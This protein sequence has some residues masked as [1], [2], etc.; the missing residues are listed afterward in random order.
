MFAVNAQWA[1]AVLNC[2]DARRSAGGETVGAVRRRNT[3][4]TERRVIVTVTTGK[5]AKVKRKWE[6]V[7]FGSIKR[8]NEG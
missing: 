7:G 5:A 1:P 8:D 4:D 2:A 6:K 3:A